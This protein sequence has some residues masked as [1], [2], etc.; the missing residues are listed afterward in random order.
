[1]VLALLTMSPL[2]GHPHGMDS[3]PGSCILTGAELN[4]KSELSLLKAQHLFFGF[5]YALVGSRGQAPAG[6]L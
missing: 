2:F 3:E 5:S 1:M 6:V 4:I